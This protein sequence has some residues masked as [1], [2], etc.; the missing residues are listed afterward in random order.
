[1]VI[2]GRKENFQ[3]ATYSQFYFNFFKI[4]SCAMWV[5]VILNISPNSINKR[6]TFK[7]KSAQL[8]DKLNKTETQQRHVIILSSYFSKFNY[9]S[10][11]LFSAHN[12]SISKSIIVIW[13]VHD[14]FSWNS[15]FCSA[16]ISS[17][18]ITSIT[19]LFLYKYLCF[20]FILMKFDGG[21]QD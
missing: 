4:I 11:L 7:C 13:A 15:S 16:P 18:A 6:V 10:I 9:Y 2:S 5:Y 14:V 8:R 21:K 12:S 3:S 20:H 19:F 17:H 1:M